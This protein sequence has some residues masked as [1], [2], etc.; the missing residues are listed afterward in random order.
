MRDL[1]IGESMEV[2]VRREIGERGVE[3]DRF[4]IGQIDEDE[5]VEHPHVAAM[6]AVVLFGKVGRHQPGGKQR[7]VESVGPCMVA[8]R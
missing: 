3:V 7:A 1:R 2:E 4:L 8:D 5:A 6:Q